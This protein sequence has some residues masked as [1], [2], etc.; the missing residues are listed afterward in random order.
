V[1]FV[2]C[3]FGILPLLLDAVFVLAGIV[4]VVAVT[5]AEHRGRIQRRMI[6]LCAALVA[7]AI[8]IVKYGDMTSV[9][10]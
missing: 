8:V 2:Y 4:V 3:E 7:L 1:Y 10:L 6:V 9:Y 5:V